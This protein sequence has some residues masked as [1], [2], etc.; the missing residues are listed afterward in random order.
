MKFFPESTKKTPS[1]LN[2]GILTF[3]KN[4]HIYNDLNF[5]KKHLYDYGFEVG[6]F[7]KAWQIILNN[8]SLFEGIFTKHCYKKVTNGNEN[9]FPEI[10][11]GIDNKAFSLFDDFAKEVTDSY[12][13]FS[14]IFQQM[15]SKKENL[16][17]ARYPHKLF[18]DWLFEKKYISE[19]TYSDFKIKASFSTKADK[20]MRLTRYY[21]LKKRYFSEISD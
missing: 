10:F 17:S 12:L 1:I 13:D 6:T 9:P 16:I 14:F 2:P 5:I 18:M 8:I 20:G 7:I 4:I 3:R 15:K 21:N 19:T 11:I